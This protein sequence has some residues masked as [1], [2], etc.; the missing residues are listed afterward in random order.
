M[1]PTTRQILASPIAAASPPDSE[2]ELLLTAAVRDGK[3]LAR[4]VDNYRALYDRDPAGTI[5]LLARLTGSPFVVDDQ[6]DDRL[7]IHHQQEEPGFPVTQP[8]PQPQSWEPWV[9]QHPQPEERVLPA[10]RKTAGGATLEVIAPGLL[11]YDGV[12]TRVSDRGTTQ[13]FSWDGWMDVEAF[14]ARGY[15]ALDSAVATR[16][17]EGTQTRLGRLYR[18]ED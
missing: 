17:A 11:T 3:I 2:R 1:P 13:V 4:E 18:G 10:V 12:R 15:T 9:T 7:V 8:Q 16:T 5:A 14:E 6:L